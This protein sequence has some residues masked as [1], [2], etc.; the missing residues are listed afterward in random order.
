MSK[1]VPWRRW[2]AG[3]VAEVEADAGVI[4]AVLAGFGGQAGAQR[5]G[6][7]AG[8]VEGAG[9][10]RRGGGLIGATA[11]GLRRRESLTSPRSEG[12]FSRSQRCR[13]CVTTLRG[14]R[15]SR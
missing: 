11:A 4:D 6:G 2:P 9:C 13:T 12:A 1:V 14:V 5:P 3:G 8:G 7:D 10:R 15:P